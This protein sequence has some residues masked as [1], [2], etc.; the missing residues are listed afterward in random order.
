MRISQVLIDHIQENYDEYSVLIEDFPD[1]MSKARDLYS[2][3][4]N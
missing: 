4:G 2:G 3:G 1:E